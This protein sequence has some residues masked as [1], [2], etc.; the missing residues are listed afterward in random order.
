LVKAI[1]EKDAV[2]VY[3]LIER[4]LPESLALT[5]LS[6]INELCRVKGS[7]RV[8]IHV[9]SSKNSPMVFEDLRGILLNNI[10]LTI[11]IHHSILDLNAVHKALN[12][13]SVS[14][15]VKYFIVIGDLPQY[16]DLIK[17]KGYQPIIIKE[18]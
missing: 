15:D 9:L 13:S 11:S 8:V 1:Y 7:K 3:L 16:I 2:H 17:S 10:H 18:V 12:D 5:V 6:K 14:M 4:N